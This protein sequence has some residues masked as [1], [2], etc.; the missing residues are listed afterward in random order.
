[1]LE[2][3]NLLNLPRVAASFA[4][5]VPLGSVGGNVTQVRGMDCARQRS[6]CLQ[7][8]FSDAVRAEF[9]NGFTATDRIIEKCPGHIVQ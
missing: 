7:F 5:P 2:E 3:L 8:P 6:A 9:S 4:S 1:M